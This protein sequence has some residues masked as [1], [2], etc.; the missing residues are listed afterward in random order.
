MSPSHATAQIWTI[1][2]E[3]PT[4]LVLL[5]LNPDTG[6]NNMT[7]QT[8]AQE[9]KHSVSAIPEPNSLEELTLPKPKDITFSCTCSPTPAGN[10]KTA[11]EEYNVPGQ[12]V[13]SPGSR[14]EV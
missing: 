9:Q 1:R 11:K 12:R 5:H 8:R 7:H 3:K 4:E 2:R 6:P 13:L 10:Q 14:D